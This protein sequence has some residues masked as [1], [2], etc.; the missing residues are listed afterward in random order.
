MDDLDWIELVG[1]VIR[2]IPL[3]RLRQYPAGQSRYHSGLPVS[4]IIIMHK[5][6]LN[7]ATFKAKYAGKRKLK[8]FT[9]MQIAISI[10]LYYDHH[11]K[12]RIDALFKPA[13]A[14]HPRQGP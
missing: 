9:V 13:Q 1:S 14:G 4:M 11:I 6:W 3:R 7:Q 5:M 10:S 8:I 12:E 2:F